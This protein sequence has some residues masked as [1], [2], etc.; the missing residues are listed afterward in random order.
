[1][2]ALK[3]LEGKVAIITGSGSGIGRGVARLFAKEGASV[4]VVDVKPEGGMET[5]DLIKKEGG[6]AFFVQTNVLNVSQV[7]SMVSRV[8]ERYGKVNVLHNNAGGWQREAHDTVLE[9]SE[10]EWDRLSDL[11][12]KSVYVVSKEVL[13]RMIEQ[14][15]GAIVNTITINAFLTQPGTAAYSAAKAGA[16]QLTRAMALDYAKYNVRVNGIAPGEIHTPLWNSTYDNLPKS[17]EVKASVLSRIPL[18]RF[19]EPEDVAFP[20]LWLAS[21]E[22]RYITG[23]IVPVDGGISAG[24]YP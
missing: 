20:A 24:V 11:N 17:D 8:V 6:E 15:G 4:A 23:Q 7:K 16:F 12:L 2:G 22:A 3:R 14:G 10:E 13:P 19:G 18:G 1:M 21:D 5:V 9:D